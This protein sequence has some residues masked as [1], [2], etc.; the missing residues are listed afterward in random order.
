MRSELIEMEE[1]G[2]YHEWVTALRTKVLNGELGGDR[3]EL[4]REVGKFQ[5]GLVVG[6]G[7]EVEIGGVGEEEARKVSFFLLF[8]PH[9]SSFPSSPLL[10]SHQVIKKLKSINLVPIYPIILST[11]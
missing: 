2:L 5:V 3:K 10:F 11:R 8:S 4:W 9:L 6:G 1:V 7:K